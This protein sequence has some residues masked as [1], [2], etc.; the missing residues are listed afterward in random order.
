M[1][2]GDRE[3]GRTPERG[4][5][6]NRARLTQ[7]QL[8]KRQQAIAVDREAN[9]MTWAAIARK[10]SMGEKEARQTYARYVDE[11][12]PLITEQSPAETLRGYLRILESARERLL[13]IADAAD[14]DSA[15][16]GALREVVRTVEKEI[17][18]QMRAGFIPRDVADSRARL[19]QEQL[20]E[21]MVDVLRR[22]GVA[23]HVY[24][25]LA[26]TLEAEAT[27]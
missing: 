25:E 24:E 10:H 13:Q 23:A 17:E 12:V 3:R 11:I 21:R 14:N 6:A 16:V 19:E 1:N 5:G 22:N 4:C 27:T 18:L 8:L 15:R 20:L 26:M 9:G 7:A 2:N